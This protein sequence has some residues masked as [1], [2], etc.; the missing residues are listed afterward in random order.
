MHKILSKSSTLTLSAIAIL[1]FLFTSCEKDVN[2]NLKDGDSRLVVEGYI[3]NGVPPYVFLTKSI[4]YF[5]KIDLNTLQNSFVHGATVKVSDGINTVTLKEYAIDTGTNGNKFS[6]YT[7]DT[8]AS[9][10]FLGVVNRTYTLTIDLPDGKHY[11]AVTKIPNPT[12]LDSVISVYPQPPFD[13]SKNPTARQIK[14]FFTDPDTLGNC[15]RY[16]TK[17]NS[18]PF[19]PGLNSVYD[20]QLINGKPFVTTFPMGENRAT[21]MKFDSLGLAYIGDTVTLKW[22]AIDKPVY[23][24]WSTYEYSLGTLGNPFSTPVSVKSNISNDG[25]GVWAGY[26]AIYK[27]VI[28]K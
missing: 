16:F 2:L 28:M 12:P 26:G 15:V 24:F 14:L 13:T 3:E 10:F 23:D 6:F 27:T 1:S 7:I 8:S 21:E 22:C 9:S 25:L 19:F 11:E 18:E 20:D 17:R 4:G 5:A